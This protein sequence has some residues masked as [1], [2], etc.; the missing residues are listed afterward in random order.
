MKTTK[1]VQER[2]FSDTGIKTSARKL[3]GSMKGYYS[4]R[5]MFQ[6]GDYPK[7]PYEWRKQ[8]VK[9]FV[10]Q[11][12]KSAFHSDTSIDV[13]NIDKEDFEYQKERKP[14]T[15]EQMSVKGW[16]SKNSQLRLDK[17]TARNAVRLRAGTTARYY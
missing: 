14:K 16:G 15:I 13:Y 5:P 7:F 8:F 9:L 10:I 4:F 1:E 2:I 17:A 11:G 12:D 6:N 3:T